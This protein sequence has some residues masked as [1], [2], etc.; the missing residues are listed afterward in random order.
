MHVNDK[1][2]SIFS[3][4]LLAFVE[5]NNILM[6]NNYIAQIIWGEKK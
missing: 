4:F 6:Y 1:S 3:N 2:I 5:I